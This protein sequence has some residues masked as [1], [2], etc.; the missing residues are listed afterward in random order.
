MLDKT[1][2][3][4]L[5]HRREGKS[6]MRQTARKTVLY[7]IEFIKLEQTKRQTEKA[8]INNSKLLLRQ[9]IKLLDRDESIF[10]AKQNSVT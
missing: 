2:T 9:Q 6:S 1:K 3:F 10:T 4:K 7:S 8:K 5:F